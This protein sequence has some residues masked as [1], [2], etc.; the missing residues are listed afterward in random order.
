MRKISSILA[1]GWV[2]SWTS[3]MDYKSVPCAKEPEGIVCAQQ[4][5][6]KSTNSFKTEEAAR[7]FA[8]VIQKV[9][10]KDVKVDKANP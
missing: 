2:V 10:A 3:G 5:P 1:V 4:I 8:E 7:E 9:N 6:R